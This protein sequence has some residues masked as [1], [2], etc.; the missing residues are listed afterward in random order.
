MV[1]S[2]AAFAIFSLL[3]AAVIALPGFAPKVEA[4]E[5]PAL[6]KGD[7]LDVRPIIG[8]CSKQVWPT[9]PARCLKNADGQARVQE[10]RL[11]TSRR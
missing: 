7:R 4:R 11:V 9:I 8:I 1:K 3:G 10:A 5:S 6:A 2:L